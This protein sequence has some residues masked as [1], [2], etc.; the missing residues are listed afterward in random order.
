MLYDVLREKLDPRS[1][2]IRE[3][4]TNEK[5]WR[6]AYDVVWKGRIHFIVVESL[7][8]RNYGHY[9]VIRDNQYISPDFTYTKIDNSL[10]CILQ[11]MIDDI[12]S[13]KYD[14]KKTLSEKIRSFAA[15]EG[16]VSYMN[17]TKW[18]ELF[19]AISKKIPDIEFQ[20]K[21]IFDETEPDVYWEYYGD[22]EL[23]YMNFAQIQ[24][25]KIKHTITNYKHIG[26]LVPS[27]AE[28]HDKKDAV[29]EILEQYRIPY[30]YIEDEQAFIVYG[31][32][33]LKNG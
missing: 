20:Y 32:R 18:C 14:R 33:Q 2:V 28:T 30:Q 10:F 3:K 5:Y 15:Q 8:R 21:S 29:L 1:G 25:L 16:F 7:F 4:A 11:S 13:G 24:W 22:E 27:E 12:E 19:A 23:K 26:V 17:N 31:Y 6:T 9:Y